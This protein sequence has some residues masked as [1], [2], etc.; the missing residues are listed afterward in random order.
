MVTKVCIHPVR[1]GSRG[2]RWNA[3]LDEELICSGVIDPEHS[4]ARALLARGITGAMEIWHAG[5]VYPS[6]TWPIEATAGRRA[7]EGDKHGP[8]IGKWT[9]YLSTEN[10]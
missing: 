5:K 2:L 1:Y 3:M 4:A 10:E 8:R 6:A 9:P 7:F